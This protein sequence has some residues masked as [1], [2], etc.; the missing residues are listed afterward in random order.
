MFFVLGHF[1]I[2]MKDGE[3]VRVK[4]KT[5]ISAWKWLL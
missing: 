1:R 3:E 4:E 2:L 5:K